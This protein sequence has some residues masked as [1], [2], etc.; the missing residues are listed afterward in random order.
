MT[1]QL[2]LLGMCLDDATTRRLSLPRT[3]EVRQPRMAP[4][5]D[6]PRA[7]NADPE[8]SHLAADRIKASGALNEQQAIVLEY[9]KRYAGLTS[10]EYA[11]RH[12]LAIGGTWK[13]HRAMFARRLPELAVIH[14]KRGDA[15]ECRTSRAKCITW[16]PL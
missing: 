3:R 12:A 1:Q 4:L 13:E 15:R 16:W 11:Q 7:A 9:V 14:V 8:T 10:A 6:V 2:D 5:V